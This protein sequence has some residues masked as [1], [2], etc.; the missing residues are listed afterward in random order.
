MNRMRTL[1]ALSLILPALALHSRAEGNATAQAQP[2]QAARPPANMIPSFV[3]D[4][5]WPKDLPP[6]W[7]WRRR[8][9]PQ[10]D[11]L[12][13]NADSRDHIWITHRSQIAEYNADGTL[14]KVLNRPGDPGQF[15]TIH[16]MYLDHKGNMWTTARE[17]HQVLKLTLDGKVLLAIGEHKV[18]A[19]SNDTLHLGRP[20]E[21]YVDA[22][23]NELYVAD[24][25][26]NHRV[27]VFDAETGKYL[28]HWGAYGKRPDDSARDRPIPNDFAKVTQFNVPHGITGSK[29]GLIYLADRTNSRVQVFKRNGEYV[30]EGFT[31]TGT[32][33]AFSVALSHDPGQEF[34]YV[35]DGT[36]HQIWILRRSTMQVEGKFSREGSA[37]G[38]VGRPHNITTDSKGNI[39]VAEADPGRR[40]QKFIFK[41]W[42]PK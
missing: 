23:T 16:G 7:T 31:R 34:V 9:E 17:E 18:T 33:G 42:V 39:Y 8:T 30:T 12:G 41:G 13:I 5:A 2:S 32:G 25:Y 28:R 11:V 1:F 19:G 22:Q 21:V 24:G 38:E 3:V 26:T 14:I 35:T 15:T 40:A 4:S 36:G 20:A 37:A 27:I 29:D 6:N 10:S